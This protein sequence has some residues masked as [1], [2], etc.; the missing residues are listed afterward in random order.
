MPVYLALQKGW[1]PFSV[2][3]AVKTAELALNLLLPERKIIRPVKIMLTPRMYK[4][5]NP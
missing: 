1:Q 5:R 2:Q 3:L 4:L